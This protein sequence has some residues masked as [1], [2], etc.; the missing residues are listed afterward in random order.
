MCSVKMPQS[1]NTL[2]AFQYGR[3]LTDAVISVCT[4]FTDVLNCQQPRL[5][6]CRG[7]RASLRTARLSALRAIAVP[8]RPS[9]HCSGNSLV[10]GNV[11]S[12]QSA[13]VA[14]KHLAHVSSAKRKLLRIKVA[15]AA[16]L[17][18]APL[19]SVLAVQAERR[20][21]LQSEPLESPEW[22][23]FVFCGEMRRFR[24]V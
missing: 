5:L 18:A 4:D 16:Q 15:G 9:T 10:C 22:W 24:G 23:H 3:R 19:Q 6:T 13:C 17:C 20:G 12:P 2:L 11:A 14:R 21:A 7:S 1:L 8:A